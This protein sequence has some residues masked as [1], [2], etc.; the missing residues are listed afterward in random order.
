MEKIEKLFFVNLIER[1]V[2][3]KIDIAS[4]QKSNFDYVNEQMNTYHEQL[5][6]QYHEQLITQYQCD[7]TKLNLYL[8]IYA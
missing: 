7:V 1:Y 8:D 6:T 5:I 3:T 4:R 2:K